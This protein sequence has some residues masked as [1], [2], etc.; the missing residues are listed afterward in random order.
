ML[1]CVVLIDSDNVA[2]IFF[3]LCLSEMGYKI[4]F[5]FLIISRSLGSSGGEP[6]PEETYDNYHL[7]HR[8]VY[9]AQTQAPPPPIHQQHHAPQGQYH[10]A[11]YH[12]YPK[13]LL[14][15]HKRKLR[16][17]KMLS[18]PTVTKMSVIL[19]F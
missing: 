19:S 13:N 1:I 11:N 6:A 14:N 7:R 15:R 8:D 2:F 16:R 9:Q 3:V 4:T 10:L 5:K 17:T 18:R 12:S